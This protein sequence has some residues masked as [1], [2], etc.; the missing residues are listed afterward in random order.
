MSVIFAER[1][2]VNTPAL[3]EITVVKYLGMKVNYMRAEGGRAAI[4]PRALARESSL[5]V[6]DQVCLFL[7]I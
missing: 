5:T 1:L 4:G 2:N 3:S 7:W 6:H